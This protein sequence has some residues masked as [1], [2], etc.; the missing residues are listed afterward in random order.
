[1]TRNDAPRLSAATLGR[2]GDLVRKPAYDRSRVT[3]GIV[4]L[5]IGNFHRAHQAVHIDDCLSADPG[6]G[7]VGASL[8][9]PDMRDA[10]MPQDWLYTVAVR[11]GTGT[12]PRIVGALCDV[13]FCGETTAPLLAAMT[14]PAIRI[15]SITV[16]EKGYCRNPATGDLDPGHPAIVADLSA[17]RPPSSVPGLLV[18]ALKAR[19]AAGLAPFT[20]LSCDNLPANG[21]TVRRLVTQYAA[22]LDDRLAAFIEGTVAFPETMVDRIVPATTDGDRAEVE[23]MT[24]LRDAWPVMAEP[25]TQWVVEDAFWGPR[26]D[27]AAAG[28][29]MVADVAPFETMKLRMLNGAHSALAYLGLLAGHETVAGAMG[30]PVLARLVA[31]LWDEVMPTLAMPRAG[32]DAYARALTGRFLNTA[33]RHRTAQIAMD[34]SQKVPQRLLAAIADRRA[35]RRGHDA[36][37]TAVAAWIAYV[38]SRKGAVDDPMAARFTALAEACLP[39]HAAFAGRMVGLRAVFADLADDGAFRDAVVAR[40]SALVE[41]GVG[42]ALAR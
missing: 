13:V 23:A 39:D 30:D 38:A 33:L 35:Q 29:Q 3:P 31:R 25:F 26:P 10:L 24:G 34:G 6:W 28:A 17:A 8:R 14:D 5:G 27:F 40:A 4:H 36:L 18:A 42:A 7:I 41:R 37:T 19:R 16:T 32:M 15:V 21:R 22:R 20:V 11:D 2:A 9:R 1:M 12:R